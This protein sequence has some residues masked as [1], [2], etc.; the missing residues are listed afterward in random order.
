MVPKTQKLL[1]TVLALLN[2]AG[3]GYREGTLVKDPVSYLWFTGN[4]T[5]ANVIIDDKKPFELTKEGLVYYQIT[6]GTHR[7]IV[8]KGEEVVVDRVLIIGNETTKEIQ[9][10]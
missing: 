6:P 9:I 5:Q 4:I 7:I 2:F 10:P 8:K 3:C 1:L